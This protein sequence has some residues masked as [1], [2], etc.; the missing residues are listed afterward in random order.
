MNDSPTNGPAIGRYMAWLKK[1][2]PY[3]YNIVIRK[4]PQAKGLAGMGTIGLSDMTFPMTAGG[5]VSIT[6]EKKDAAV[7]STWADTLKNIIASAS[8]VYLTK[9]QID[10]QKKLT[11]LQLDRV[12]QGLAPLDIDPQTMG[13]PGP[14]VS[15][16]VTS[17]TKKLLLWGG[18]GVA[19]L[20]IFSQ[21]SGGRGRRA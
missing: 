1:K 20:V 16:G 13:L 4:F 5:S 17:D 14:S 15:F 6:E 12:Q 9:A 11:S 3:F 2:Q 21:L 10:A 8:Q 18:L 7:T 19:A